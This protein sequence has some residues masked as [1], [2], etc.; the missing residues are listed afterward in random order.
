MAFRSTSTAVALAALCAVAGL[1]G[2]ASAWSSGTAACGG[3]DSCGWADNG[4]ADCASGN[5]CLYTG[6]NFTGT[7]RL[8]ARP[9]GAELPT[10]AVH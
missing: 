8:L 4:G 6:A 1:V 7:A 10:P 3:N 2:T 9:G 5:L